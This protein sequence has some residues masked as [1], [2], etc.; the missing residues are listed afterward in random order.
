[1]SFNES[2]PGVLWLEFAGA[3]GDHDLTAPYAFIR[4]VDAQI[5]GGEQHELI[6]W[7]RDGQ[8]VLA[9]DPS[10][11]YSRISGQG[12]FSVHLEQLDG[13]DCT[14]ECTRV[15][16]TDLRLLVDGHAVAEY[17]AQKGGWLRVATAARLHGVRLEPEADGGRIV[18][19]VIPQRQSRGSS[20]GREAA[21]HGAD[22]AA[23]AGIN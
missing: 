20:A 4:L 8:W 17:D 7:L 23:T 14:I 6:G 9:A 19:D 18:F 2:E 15:H 1:M 10:I 13:S 16:I 3:V 12:V 22:A 21:A 5:E 11:S